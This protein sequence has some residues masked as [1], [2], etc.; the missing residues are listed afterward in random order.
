MRIIQE[1]F[2]C[3]VTAALMAVFLALA[4]GA[5][6]LLFANPLLFVVLVV[7]IVVLLALTSGQ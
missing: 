7:A 6:A 5:I 2:D 1:L 3:V 4:G